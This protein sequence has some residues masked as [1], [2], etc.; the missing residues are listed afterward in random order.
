MVHLPAQS[1]DSGRHNGR[2]NEVPEN[3]T[4]NVLQQL[5][6]EGPLGLW[7]GIPIFLGLIGLTLWLGKRDYEH[8]DRSKWIPVFTLLRIGALMALMWM[9]LGPTYVQLLSNRVTKSIA[10]L[11][12]QSASM[13]LVD[14]IDES[15]NNLRW[16]DENLPEL[17]LLR[18]M[19][20][21]MGR[22]ANIG[23]EIRSMV[24]SL[25]QGDALE[26]M[27]SEF[28]KLA[29]Q[30]DESA[31]ELRSLAN[32]LPPELSDQAESLRML[33]T[34]LDTQSLNSPSGTAMR[35]ALSN[36]DGTLALQ[37][38][39]EWNSIVRNLG[40]LTDRIAATKEAVPT[41]PLLGRL[42]QGSSRSRSDKVHQLLKKA[43]GGWLAELEEKAHIA[44]YQF[45]DQVHPLSKS[46][47]LEDSDRE[48]AAST[49]LS[50]ALQQIA[51]DSAD[52][53]LEAALVFTDGGHNSGDDP[54]KVAGHLSEVPLFIV[55]IGNTKM[56]R[57]VILHHTLAPRAVYQNDM[58]VVDS[59]ITAYR[60]SGEQV[61]AEL[62]ADGAVVDQ[63]TIA[64]RREIFD[65]RI[66]LKW[67]AS[68][69][70]RHEFQVRIQALEDEKSTENNLNKL[71]IHV[72][73]D[74]I[75]VLIAD[76][77]PRWEFRYLVNLF[78]R[79][80]RVEYE[81]LI[82]EPRHSSRGRMVSP[83]TFPFD[84]EQWMRYRII[85]L[86]DVRP[87][88]LTLEHQ[89]LLRRYV[90][91]YGGNLIVIAGRENMPSAFENQPLES[92]L[93]VE[94]GDH[95][96][97]QDQ[98]FSLSVTPEGSYTMPV[99][100]ESS[101]VASDSLWREMSRRLPVYSL[102]EYSQ[103]KPTGHSLLAATEI[104]AQGRS[105]N[106]PLRS[107]LSWH[108]VGRGRVVYLSA[109]I[110]YQLRYRQ[111]DRHHHR[112][113]GQL[114][115]WSIARDL[116]EGSR[117]VRL[118]TDKSSYE[119]GEPI[120]ITGSLYR[121]D[122]SVFSGAAPRVTVTQGESLISE[123]LLN[124]NPARPGTYE[125]NLNG[126]PTGKV[127][128]TL[129]GDPIPALLASEGYD[130]EIE[131]I[132]NID[133]SG[134]LEFRHPLCNLALLN[135]VART[136]NGVLLPPAALETAIANLDLAPKITESTKRIPIWNQWK[137]LWIF[138]GCLSLEWIGRKLI[139]LV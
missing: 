137:Y 127:K 67:K 69:L 99:Q 90:T 76:N 59:M 134:A 1:K 112:F 104:N 73:E 3:E 38:A 122:G 9:L 43:E 66:Q 101:S 51:M 33:A 7:I 88:Q 21:E 71:S 6:F 14:P 139:G 61:R 46:S 50:S 60:C 95:P 16:L 52:S 138:V 100:L 37:F 41:R 22:L 70:G 84:Y 10:I 23:A 47:K 75:R 92:L 78:D 94:Q 13:K 5:I 103:L 19:D 107:Y 135:Q 79:D 40:N 87:E 24:R 28:E 80:E 82:F 115:R 17:Q 2:M 49:D 25:P 121:L 128:L 56:P 105:S 44:R 81:Q 120:R 27:E 39:E 54:T 85:I 98:G 34:Q 108:Y 20:Q 77:L 48:Y 89:Q 124:E 42:E 30:I 53:Q 118:A 36:G 109:P 111:G 91:E 93:P 72:M 125:G 106:A 86:G 63:Q 74:K 133:P 102:S 26:S 4:T 113:W 32:S 123:I 35:T 68:Q 129:G 64:I 55:P 117:T 31:N 96:I 116:A 97:R 58:V 62:L 83:P 130:G 132:V 8:T 110:S 131:T 119:R 11:V 126:A 114:L 57:D 15:G 12:D 29:L 18:S 45:G 136:G 65:S